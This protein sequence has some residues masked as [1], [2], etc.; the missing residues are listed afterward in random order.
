MPLS[1][2]TK[3]QI[4]DLIK[5]EIQPEIDAAVAKKA[6]IE[7]FRSNLGLY[8]KLPYIKVPYIKIPY[9]KI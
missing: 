3:S 5:R 6:E 7:K 1:D 8:L 9:V 4:L 2:K